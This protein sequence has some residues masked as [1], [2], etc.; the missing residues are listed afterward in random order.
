MAKV[1]ALIPPTNLPGSINNEYVNEPTFYNLHK[2]DTKFDYTPMD[3]LHI[4]GR[5]GDQPYNASF[6]PVYGPILVDPIPL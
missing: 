4:S 3:K 5:Y 1:I 2:I 6:A